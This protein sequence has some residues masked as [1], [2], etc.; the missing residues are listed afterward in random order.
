MKNK[1]EESKSEERGAKSETAK[2]GQRTKENELGRIDFSTPPPAKT[3]FEFEIPSGEND[4]RLEDDGVPSTV[5]AK[6]VMIFGGIAGR[7]LLI[8]DPADSNEYFI[9][10]DEWREQW[11]P[12]V[13]GRLNAQSG[14]KGEERGARSETA[15]KI[16]GRRA[17]REERNGE[18][19]KGEES[20]IAVSP[21]AP[22][23]SPIDSTPL[24]PRP[25]PLDSQPG[26]AVPHSE[27]YM[28]PTA[29]IDASRNRRDPVKADSPALLELVES[30]KDIGQLERI[31]L[32]KLDKAAAAACGKKFRVVAG[33]RR[34]QSIIL[35]GEEIIKADV[36]ADATD[37]WEAKAR[38]AENIQRMDYN[39]ME[40]ARILGE[41]AAAGLTVGEI[42]AE[43][44][45]SDDAVRRHLALLRLTKPIHELV[46]SGRLPVHQAELIAR[47]GDPAKQ[48]A[49]A[50]S[51]TRM[52]W[53]A[54]AAKWSA[55]GENQ[56]RGGRMV[57]TPGE[58]A[59]NVDDRD[60]ILPMDALRKEVS[61]AMQGLAAAGWIK[62]EREMGRPFNPLAGCGCCQGCTHNTA[63][64]ADQPMLFAGLKPQGSDKRG[65]CLNKPCYEAKSA[66]YEK[67]RAKKRKEEE[68]EQ[69]ARAAKA[70]KAGLA[71]CQCGHV[72]DAGEEFSKDGRCP[73]CQKNEGRGARGEGRRGENEWDKKRREA[74][75][76]AKRFPSNAKER[77][78]VAMWKHLLACYKAVGVHLAGLTPVQCDLP[79]VRTVLRA[80]I[81]AG[82]R[83]EDPKGLL[84][85]AIVDLAKDRSLLGGEQ[86][87]KIWAEATKTRDYQAPH[88]VEYDGSLGNVPLD[89]GWMAEIETTEAVA[90][91]WGVTTPA[92]PVEEKESK[93]EERGAKSETAKKEAE[94]TTKSTKS[95]KKK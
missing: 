53:D 32:R 6:F 87:A 46:A 89:K 93:G 38:L 39:H 92:R 72:E 51:A 3:R 61:Y 9:S 50:E 21:L 24:A 33:H 80:S 73:K 57:R 41:S 16:E 66:E 18:E 20:A 60:Y 64:Y 23:P 34:L 25:S 83:I 2:K 10:P 27:P 79:V 88:V 1:S 91:A 55:Q 4:P 90:E 76:K 58:D 95:T 74:R 47:V 78:A 68:K 94:E 81:A 71:V 82:V 65:F 69:Q 19:R 29:E 86:L 67:V 5:V 17:K 11:Q 75:E 62:I 85:P 54:K 12:F 84:F 15:K 13:V 49:L 43:A 44:K 22:R 28:V 45:Y 40:L 56:W 59:Q 48:I 70:R 31:V 14:S 42:A 52:A 36:Y 8:Q 35:A 7:Q 77:F 30:I 37:V 26:A 63:T